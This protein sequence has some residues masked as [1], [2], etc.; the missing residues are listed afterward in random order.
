MVRSNT[1]QRNGA[2]R[3][4]RV[5]RLPMTLPPSSSGTRRPLV[6]DS[7]PYAAAKKTARSRPL[8]ENSH[9]S[10]RFKS[11][12]EPD[13]KEHNSS[14]KRP[15]IRFSPPD[16]ANTITQIGTKVGYL[17]RR[18]EELDTEDDEQEE[19][20]WFY[21]VLRPTTYLY[22]YRS[23]E[24]ASPCGV[25][26]LEYLRRIERRADVI[27]RQSKQS[28]VGTS[29]QSFCIG[30][31]PED[32]RLTDDIFDHFQEQENEQVDIVI[33]VNEAGEA[34]EWMEAIR[35]HRF[36]GA[37]QHSNN[38]ESLQALREQ[39]DIA[40][41]EKQEAIEMGEQCATEAEEAMD[42]LQQGVESIAD[43]AE[44]LLERCRQ[45]LESVTGTD[46]I[47]LSSGIRK[48]KG[49]AE[50]LFAAFHLMEQMFDTTTNEIQQQEELLVQMR[51]QEEQLTEQLREHT[52]RGRNSA[53]WRQQEEKLTA[54]VSVKEAEIE[55]A[56]QDIEEL[57]EELQKCQEELQEQQRVVSQLQQSSSADPKSKSFF[58]SKRITR[59]R[60][61][62]KKAISSKDQTQF[63]DEEED[64]EPID[65]PTPIRRVNSSKFVRGGHSQV[66]SSKATQ[67]AED[68][69]VDEERSTADFEQ[70][71]ASKSRNSPLTSAMN[72]VRKR[73][74]SR[75]QPKSGASTRSRNSEDTASASSEEELAPKGWTRLESRRY[76]GEYYYQ[77]NKTGENSWVHPDK[78]DKTSLNSSKSVPH[79]RTQKRA[80]QNPSA[81][82]DSTNRVRAKPVQSV[83]NLEDSPFVTRKKSINPSKS[84]PPRSKSK[85]CPIEPDISPAE[86]DDAES[87]KEQ[88]KSRSYKWSLPK[89]PNLVKSL[90]SSRK[91]PSWKGMKKKK[92]VPSPQET[93][94]NENYDDIDGRHEF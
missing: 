9:H 24:D 64:N 45:T 76:P 35:N 83:I 37:S 18:S 10:T 55:K 50:S 49:A 3:E 1:S 32:E 2:E 67:Q 70:D 11:F 33:D 53:R 30:L 62:S 65:A 57:S 20:E 14:N 56:Q 40:I 36:D 23:K 84:E 47:R 89:K 79:S 72:I 58:G 41:Q 6:K 61:I 86:K 92:A 29:K 34:N 60:S 5:G 68:F 38:E 43:E 12:Q 91:L 71:C 78:K 93:F 22:C 17:K 51:G 16:D 48:E 46:C 75:A 39:L 54:T 13:R 19:W 80:H 44:D 15:R 63:Q 27:D 73:V 69:D 85:R 88:S 77:N 25:I 94:E 7:A 87:L 42:E 26:D 4:R 59:T 28:F 81:R 52:L 90:T 66:K 31:S 21:C 8:P 82:S 74:A